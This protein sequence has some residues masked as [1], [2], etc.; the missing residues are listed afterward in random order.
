VMFRPIAR[1]HFAGGSERGRRGVASR[2]LG[3]RLRGHDESIP[4]LHFRASL[5]KTRWSRPFG[6]AADGSPVSL[7]AISLIAAE[8]GDCL[9]FSGP[10]AL[11]AARA[12]PSA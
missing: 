11:M 12:G 1:G 2:R 6:F 9:P 3:V 8:S 5:L 10:P 4:E 7:C